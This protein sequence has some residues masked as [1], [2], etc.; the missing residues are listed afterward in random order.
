M[1]KDDL[2]VIEKHD[3]E[4]RDRHTSQE[5]H[6]KLGDM[7]RDCETNEYYACKPAPRL[8]AV[9]ERAMEGHHSRDCQVE[10]R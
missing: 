6:K 5:V 1:V 9:N 8:D 4:T 10:N 3:R 7:L 2:L